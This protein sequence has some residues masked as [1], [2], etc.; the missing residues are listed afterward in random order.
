MYLLLINKKVIDPETSEYIRQDPPSASIP[1]H[2]VNKT[3]Q[4]AQ[5]VS[6]APA[7]PGVTVVPIQTQPEQ[8]VQSQPL[9][10]GRINAPPFFTHI[11]LTISTLSVLDQ[12]LTWYLSDGKNYKVTDKE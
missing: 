3:Q 4:V 1:H 7:E 8:K 9:V 6:Q 12:T 2:P 11:I 5:T 10:S